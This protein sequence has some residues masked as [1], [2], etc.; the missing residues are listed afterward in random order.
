MTIG[1]AYKQQRLLAAVLWHMQISNVGVFCLQLVTLS[2][3][4]P[5]AFSVLLSSVEKSTSVGHCAGTWR[6]PLGAELQALDPAA[7]DRATDMLRRLLDRRRQLIMSLTRRQRRRE[8]PPSREAAGAAAQAS[9]PLLVPGEIPPA[10]GPQDA[11]PAQPG[12]MSRRPS[13]AAARGDM[14]G[15]VRARS[16]TDWPELAAA[17]PNQLKVSC[18]VAGGAG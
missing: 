13:A 18:S 8:Q 14:P 7:L 17:H 11:V 9:V 3:P 1:Q 12:R 16:D 6:G 10:D 4:D 2:H 15:L 5:A